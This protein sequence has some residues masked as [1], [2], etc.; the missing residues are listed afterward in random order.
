MLPTGHMMKRCTGWMPQAMTQK[1]IDIEEIIKTDQMI[2]LNDFFNIHDLLGHQQQRF[3]GWL[4]RWIRLIR[5]VS[6][7]AL[8]SNHQSPT[9]WT[10][11]A[12]WGHGH[13]SQ[14]DSCAAQTD[15]W[16]L[17]LNYVESC[18]RML[19]S[20]SLDSELDDPAMRVFFSRE[21]I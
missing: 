19:G 16:C 13:R 15:T 1:A 11:N 12:S 7:Q 8:I 6:S 5:Q 17:S 10:G 14:W 2:C 4:H 9:G 21:T 18:F 3:K 20:T